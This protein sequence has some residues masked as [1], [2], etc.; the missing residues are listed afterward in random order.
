MTNQNDAMNLSENHEPAA[1]GAL[2]AVARR[3]TWVSVLLTA[4]IFI[5]GLVIGAGGALIAVR[6]EML[7]VVHNP[8]EAPRRI[9]AHLQSKLGLSDEQ[10]RQ[11]EGVV[12][13]RQAALQ[14][15]RREVQPQVEAELDLAADEIGQLLDDTQRRQWDA[16]VANIRETWVPPPP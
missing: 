3:R 13:Q 2:P 7:H 12:R 15:I 4:I 10:T 1:G 5:S 6:R 11:V 16:M 14:A 8:Q 9:A